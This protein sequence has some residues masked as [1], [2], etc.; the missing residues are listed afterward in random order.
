[1]HAESQGTST[2]AEAPVRL[3]AAPATASDGIDLEFETI[4]E[5]IEAGRPLPE[6]LD[7]VVARAHAVLGAQE[8]L[9]L[10]R[11]GDLLIGAAQRGFDDVSPTTIQLSMVGSI[12][13][14]VA[15]RRRAL[16]L[17][18]PEQDP[19]FHEAPPRRRPIASLV[20]LPLEARG[21]VLGVL[22]AATAEK[23]DFADSLMLLVVLAD[24]ATLAIESCRTL[25]RE[26][27]RSRLV[28]LLRYVTTVEYGTDLV[29]S[30]TPVADRIV[31]TL[32]AEKV[33]ILLADPERAAYV[34]L[35]VSNT[36]LG[37][38]QRE[39]GLDVVPMTAPSPVVQVIKTGRSMLVYD[40]P[41]DP[42]MWRPDVEQL[43][44]ASVM[45]SPI[46][47]NGEQRGALV[48]SSTRAY[49]FQPDDL[50]TQDLIAR[51]LGLALQHSEL[52]DDLNRLESERLQR[53]ERD[54]FIELLA[55]DLKNPLS[56]LKG[57]AQL[58]GRRLAAGDTDYTARA[59]S[60]MNQKADQ[61][62]RLMN[63]ILEVTRMS[64]GTFTVEP[65]SVD[66]VEL[67]RGEVESAQVTSD[68]HTIRVTAPPALPVEADPERMGQVIQNL[69]SNAI[70]YS[71][72][73]GPVDVTVV[74]QDGEATISVCDRGSGIAPADL[75][76]IFER[77]FRGQGQAPQVAGGRGLGLY[78]S[79]EIA[80]LHAGRIWA[81]PREG[82]GSCFFVA[83]PERRPD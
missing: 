5:A 3:S 37:Q 55:H 42:R 67:V 79:R 20:S 19:R 35:G 10:L 62:D 70:R 69:L 65:A 11:E 54:D 15:S 53:M 75:P 27:R 38:K 46:E 66:L 33:D 81:S 63:D 24:L 43:G 1:M 12:E 71:P 61:L 41:H 72:R 9:V 59:L 58:A 77:S 64:V 49:A 21:K 13:G 23:T 32:G 73:G 4:T 78:I 47:V 74:A 22:S 76:H 44:L 14:W 28:D 8:T 82:G 83:L 6:I 7:L 16:A 80:R 45:L 40:G 56:V 57:Y 26:S 29:A 48:C 34:S 18:D 68:K 60:V 52:T 39:L 17:R 2:P 51:R 25:A 30:L 36:P 31:E 50:D